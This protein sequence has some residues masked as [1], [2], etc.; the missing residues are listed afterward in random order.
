MAGSG[1]IAWTGSAAAQTYVVD[2][3][4]GAD[5]GGLSL[6][7]N[8]YLAGQFTL[9]VGHEINALEGWMIYPTLLGDLPVV[10]VLYGDDGGVPDLTNEIYSQL[11]LVPA[12]GIPFA[13]GWH[14]ISG[15]S[16]PVYGDT[17]YWLAFEVPTE[18]FGSGAMPPTPLV[19]LD[20][21]AVD[22]GA[23]YLANT[24]SRLGIRVLPEPGQAGM[25]VCGAVGLC[26]AGRVRRPRAR[27]ASALLAAPDSPS[28]SRDCSEPP[29]LFEHST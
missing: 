20:L 16:I 1:A 23:G 27:L 2:T 12:S 29:A 6:T 5:T 18:D 7:R 10:A 11:F 4:P 21:Y 28:R 9:D 24:T 15:L 3:G 8:Q 19:E 13:A 17:P 22:S 14:G 25:L 26:F